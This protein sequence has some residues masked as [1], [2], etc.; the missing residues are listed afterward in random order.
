[1]KSFSQSFITYEAA[2]ALVGAALAHAKSQS[3][4]VAVAVVD[5]S[6]GLVA[7]GR[8]DAAAPPVG[9][10]ATD[11]AYTAATLRKASAAFGESMLSSPTLGLGVGTRGRFLTWGGG[12]PI[13]EQGHLVGAIGVSGAKEPE[14]IACAVAAIEEVGFS[15]EV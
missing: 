6:G 11:K 2:Q 3:W 4:S 8:D 13:Y 5:P 15:A 7:F 9:G 12:L 14:D 10:F 1:M